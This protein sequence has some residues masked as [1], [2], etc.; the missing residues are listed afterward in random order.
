MPSVTLRTT[1]TS[2]S[3]G[4]TIGE[5]GSGRV[6]E[7]K[8]ESGS[9][10]AVKILDP[11]K[12]TGNKLKRFRNE[13]QFGIRNT[14]ANIITIVDHGLYG[15]GK[16]ASPFYVMPRYSQTLRNLIEGGIGSV[17]VLPY[18]SQILNGVEAAHLKGIFHRDL[19]PEN[20]LHSLE[21]DQLVVADFGIAAF[22]EEELYTAVET[23]HRDR[24][25]NFQYAAPEQRRRGQ[26][27]DHLADIYGLGLILN[28]MFTK[29]IPQG[30]Q[31]RPIGAVDRDFAYLDDL[32]AQMIRQNPADRPSTIR[33]IK[34]QLIA[35]HN[36]F[37]TQQ[38]V[39]QLEN[40]VIPETE[41]DD[42]H[43]ADPIR[44]TEVDYQDNQLILTLSQPVNANWRH[45]FRNFGN[46]TAVFGKG[47]D[48]FEFRGNEAR[49]PTR[50][51]DAEQILAYFKEWLP[52]VN[53]KYEEIVS[54]ERANAMELKRQELRRQLEREEERQRVLS[55]LRV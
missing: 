23:G 30:T 17:K 42:P 2:Y 51:H 45:A 15:N 5:G 14:H 37:V 34:E 55:R 8:D 7:A 35:R 12:A 47:P 50:A 49:I 44:L 38:R 53:K 27:V 36:D 22:E 26:S 13:V 40:T 10:F 9:T 52:R 46:H 16:S 54:S 1:F 32:V 48:Q 39:S 20:I 21:A 18:F 11:K 43:I 33:Q 3:T 19:K 29:E 28:E 6:Y 25:A 4:R 31:Y 24:L 41:I